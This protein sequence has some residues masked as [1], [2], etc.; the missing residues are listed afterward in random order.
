MPGNSHHLT[1]LLVISNLA[2]RICTF[3]TTN[4]SNLVSVHT[5]NM[6]LLNESSPGNTQQ[7]NVINNFR[8]TIKSPFINHLLIKPAFVSRGW[9]IVSC[10]S[11]ATVIYTPL[12][13]N[14]S[15]AHTCTLRHKQGMLARVSRHKTET[16]S[17][18][19]EFSRSLFSVLCGFIIIILLMHN[20]SMKE[21]NTTSLHSRG[22]HSLFSLLCLF[23]LSSFAFFYLSFSLIKSFLCCSYCVFLFCL[24]ASSSLLHTVA[25]AL[26]SFFDIIP[27]NSLLD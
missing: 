10:L 19:N 5:L 24:S 1:F 13:S 21:I 25:P 12:H 11:L 26:L 3:H 23:A 9:M 22:R 18:P 7:M 14:W 16:H 2:P 8:R 4:K 27:S 20:A 17:C 6:A 15:Y